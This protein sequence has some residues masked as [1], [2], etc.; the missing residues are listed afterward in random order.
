MVGYKSQI[1]KSKQDSD[2]GSS[3]ISDLLPPFFRDI[4]RLI[5]DYLL[6]KYRFTPR[7]RHIL[8]VIFLLLAIKLDYLSLEW[9]ILILVVIGS[10]EFLLSN[11]NKLKDSKK[12]TIEDF[13][14]NLDKHT[15]P[16]IL[17]F[18]EENTL[19]EEYILKLLKFKKYNTNPD[20]HKKI[21]KTQ[22]FNCSTIDYLVKVGIIDKIP[23]VIVKS[24]IFLCQNTLNIDTFNQLHKKDS[25]NIKGA[26]L[27]TNSIQFKSKNFFNK[28]L[29]P[30]LK[31]TI[32][33]SNIIRK[34]TIL[35]IFVI[36]VP[37]TPLIWYI[38]VISNPKPQTPLELLIGSY[39]TSA[40]LITLLWVFI[41][42]IY[43]KII[44]PFWGILYRS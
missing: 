30:L 39:F 18:L 1:N 2:S 43:I 23:D 5:L 7:F 26:L 3:S 22:F 28:I 40:L 35:H 8:A 44:V 32:F 10:V 36:S 19:P 33:I 34:I 42:F 41:R 21:I 37:L 13:F 12:K 11:W 20:L 25:I 38:L 31:L 17:N 24:Y 27:L 6:N 29:S 14:S 9:S 16:E 4:E 15:L